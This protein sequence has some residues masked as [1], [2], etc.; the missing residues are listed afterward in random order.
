MEKHV[1]TKYAKLTDK[2]KAPLGTVAN[3]ILD[4]EVLYIQVSPDE[5]EPEWISVDTFLGEVFGNLMEHKKFVDESLRIYHNKKNNPLFN[6]VK[7]MSD[8]SKA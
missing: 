5:E 3:V 8:V 7:I 6:I 2:D 4:D 1:V